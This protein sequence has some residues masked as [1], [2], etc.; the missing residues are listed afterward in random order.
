MTPPYGL[1]L[2]GVQERQ[3]P[4]ELVSVLHLVGAQRRPLIQQALTHRLG[5]SPGFEPV[6]HGRIVQDLPEQ[7]DGRRFVG[8]E[9]VHD[10]AAA[11]SPDHDLVAPELSDRPERHALAFWTERPARA[12]VERATAIRA[13]PAL[14]TASA[15]K[16]A[17][18]IDAGHGAVSSI[19]VQCG[20]NCTV[21]VPMPTLR[22]FATTIS[23]GPVPSMPP[24]AIAS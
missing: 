6:Q 10:L 7:P 11:H 19:L 4:V 17:D 22:P 12:L 8:A 21:T 1:E 20:S 2:A 15:R 3:R 9:L 24:L 16:H 18:F 23:S 14:P 13:G 5:G